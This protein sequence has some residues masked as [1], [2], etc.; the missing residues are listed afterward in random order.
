MNLLKNQRA[1]DLPTGIYQNLEEQLMSNIIRHCKDY[2]EPI[3]TDKWLM[4]K[5]AEIGKLNRENIRIIAKS[6][7]L[8]QAAMERMLDGVAG[9]VINELEPGFK[10]LAKEGYFDDA[11]PVKKSRNVNQVVKIMKGQARDT[12]NLCNT[13]MLYKAREAFRGLVQNVASRALEVANKQSF[14]DTLNQKTAETVTGAAS[15][16]QA[17]RQCIKAFSKMGI[18]AFVDKRGREW[19]PEAYVNMAMRNTSKNMADEMQN[20][21]CRDYGCNLIEID[22]HSGARP[23]C[24]KDQGKL[25]NL[26][27]ESG[28]AEDV[29]GKKI[30]FYP[31]NSSSYGEPDGILGINCTH[32]KY[33]FIPGLSV[34]RFF[35]AEDI[36]SGGKLYKETQIQRAL[37]RDV[38]KQKRECMLLK[39]LEDTEGFEVSAV[40]LK[41]KEAKLKSYVDGNAQLHRRKDREQVVGFDRGVSSTAVAANKVVNKRFAARAKDDKIKS[42]IKDAGIKGKV[43][44]RAQKIDVSD[45][46]FD[47]KHINKDRLH[48]VSRGDAERFIREADVSVTKWNGR[49]VNYYGPNG[50]TFVDVENNNIRTAFRKE[51]FDERTKRMREV[52]K[53]NDKG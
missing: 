16:Q 42:E 31:W 49:F 40:K 5:L 47:E 26:D 10:W 12:L 45:Y 32:H 36:G 24:A 48:S 17:M 46:S 6:T 27:N 52:L 3:A 11:V 4:K 43:D 9:Q 35:P 7:G 44:L 34:Q 30:R 33:P 22:S 39:E 19:T 14:L 23:K 13:T 1:A 41:Q 21:R 28:Y 38:R 53:E 25:Y 51:Q 2:G 20:E 29:H 15:R 18:P 37:E 8:S 50:A